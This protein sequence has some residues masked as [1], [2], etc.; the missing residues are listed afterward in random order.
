MLVSKGFQQVHG[1]HYDE[2]F[3]PV[4]KMDSICFSLFIVEAKG[5]EDHRAIKEKTN[6][7]I[8]HRRYTIQ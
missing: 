4:A 3:T 1:I 6:A 8:K 5:W 7:E 2:I